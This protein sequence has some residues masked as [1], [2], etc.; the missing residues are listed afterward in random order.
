MAT[1]QDL[2]PQQMEQSVYD[3]I[4]R[5]VP[6]ILTV[7]VGDSWSNLH[8]YVLAERERTLLLE[9]PLPDDSRPP[10][11][12]APGEAVGVSFKHKHHK[13]IFNTRVVGLQSLHTEDGCALHVLALE[14]PAKMQRLQRRAYLRADV[15]PNR[16]VRATFW[17]GGREAEPAGG[18]T[19]TPVWLG[20][21]ANISAGGF[22]LRAED[23]VADAVDVGDIVGARLTFGAAD[24]AVFAD[25]QC[26][27]IEHC[28]VGVLMGFQFIG[29]D[30]SAEGRA[31]I[32]FISSKVSEYQRAA[33]Q[34]SVA[35]LRAGVGY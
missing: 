34:A 9:L 25:A 8:S 4:A 5:R 28:G 11:E 24:E 17:L 1:L 15:P 2:D 13:H 19:D 29:L 12:F 21:V 7:R 27:H 14:A 10:H 18:S 3:A 26:R 16:V 33:E 31:A 32:Q 35:R 23:N 20:R 30:Q 6:V 22:Q